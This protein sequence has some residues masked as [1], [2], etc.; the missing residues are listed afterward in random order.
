MTAFVV[1]ALG[2]LLAEAELVGADGAAGRAAAIGVE[3]AAFHTDRANARDLGALEAGGA[4]TL[5]AR[6][7]VATESHCAIGST[8]PNASSFLVDAQ[9][10]HPKA[11]RDLVG[12]RF[13]GGVSVRS[14]AKA[15]EAAL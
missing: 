6:K 5:E 3:V 4:K 1:G 15:L 10:G 2:V 11:A 13:E 8:Y 12:A 14:L 9:A 7:P